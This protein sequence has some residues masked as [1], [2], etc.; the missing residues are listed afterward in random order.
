MSI[1]ICHV[2]QRRFDIS[3]ASP[4]IRY[5]QPGGHLQDLNSNF[6]DNFVYHPRHPVAFLNF[7]ET[8]DYEDASGLIVSLNIEIA[9][10]LESELSGSTR[11]SE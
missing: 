1:S 10:L 7:Q 5:L 8:A 9:S 6:F 11:V 2:P 4:A 3:P